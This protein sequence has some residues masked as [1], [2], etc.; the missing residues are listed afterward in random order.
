MNKKWTG[1]KKSLIFWASKLFLQLNF[2]Y[3]L[4]SSILKLV[5]SYL[6]FTKM[7]EIKLKKFS[8]YIF[9][10]LLQ[11][12]NIYQMNVEWDDAGEVHKHQQYDMRN[13]VSRGSWEHLTC[14]RKSLKNM[15]MKSQSRRIWIKLGS[16]VLARTLNVS[17]TQKLWLGSVVQLF[18]PSSAAPFKMIFALTRRFPMPRVQ[19][20]SI[21]F[22][23]KRKFFFTFLWK[24]FASIFVSNVEI[25]CGN[26]KFS[27]Y[28]ELDFTIFI[29]IRCSHLSSSHIL[30]Q[31]KNTK[32][33]FRRRSH[34]VVC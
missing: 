3:A 20:V 19:L 26:L 30:L 1:N 5:D 7:W 31:P 23:G 10:L 14:C 9:F 32:K 21:S 27:L 12:K 4:I 28:V 24:F 18:T 11:M 6:I 2:C 25:P 22:A 13:F 29:L 34:R 16:L 15:K 8:S 17:T 33:F